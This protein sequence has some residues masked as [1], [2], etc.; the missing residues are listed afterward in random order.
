MI[1]ARLRSLEEYKRHSKDNAHVYD[2]IRQL[3]RDL[4]HR[5]GSEFT[6]KG[7]SYPAAQEVD[8]LVDYKYHVNGNI[9][10]RE[11]L[12]CPVT[13]LNNR[14]R[15]AVHFMDFELN[16]HAGS[17]IYLAEQLTPLYSFLQPRYPDLI[18]SEYLG[19]GVLP[20]FVNERGI[21][22]EDATRLSFM[23]NELDC[24][25]SFDCLEHI[26]SFEQAFR[27][28]YRV[29]KPGA[30]MFWTAPF[31]RDREQNEVRATTAADGSITYHL[32]AEY[33]GDPVKPEGGI[34]CY[35]YF[36]WEL[37]GMLRGIGFKDA[38]VI[39]YW[40]DTLGY[41]SDDMFLFCAIK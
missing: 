34:L 25:M 31:R 21:R 28:A 2:R 41:Y 5:N 7:F 33:H 23:D 19:D 29:L 8:F 40:S 24:Y 35:T 6:V 36:G 18:G 38:Y 14:L 3:E 11:R 15:A 37:F 27:E 12:I 1:T 10:W 32:P 17:R 13:G 39:T 9:N 4:I 22:H 20:G 26:P 16:V 30:A